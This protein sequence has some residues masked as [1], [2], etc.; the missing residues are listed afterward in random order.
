MGLGGQVAGWIGSVIRLECRTVM[1]I[2]WPRICFRRRQCL[3]LYFRDNA[4]P[5]KVV[6]LIYVSAFRPASWF[7]ARIPTVHISNSATG[8][9][10]KTQSPQQTTPS[11]S[12]ATPSRSRA[13]ENV[14]LGVR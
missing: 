6:I 12:I 7:S 8:S 14:Y 3:C 2:F 10:T 9:T 11:S 13:P 4:L 1:L 5:L